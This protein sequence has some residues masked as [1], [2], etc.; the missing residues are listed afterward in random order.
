[1]QYTG[2]RDECKG[3]IIDEIGTGRCLY[4]FRTDDGRVFSHSEN[5]VT[6][7]ATDSGLTFYIDFDP[8]CKEKYLTPTVLIKS[9][10][11]IFLIP[12]NGC[13]TE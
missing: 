9:R 11:M 3:E 12:D 2:R 6:E 8:L 10:F 5:D 1:M 4:E 7:T 13:T